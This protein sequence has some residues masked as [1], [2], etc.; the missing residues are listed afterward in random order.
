M[1]RT[2]RERF[3]GTLDYLSRY[4]SAELALSAKAVLIKRTADEIGADLAFPG[5]YDEEGDVDQFDA[6]AIKTI[7]N[8]TAAKVGQDLSLKGNGC[9]VFGTEGQH[10]ALRGLLMCQMAFLGVHYAKGG[11]N[12]TEPYDYNVHKEATVPFYLKKPEEELKKA[13]RC[14]LT[15]PGSRREDLILAAYTKPG[16]GN[17]T[18]WETTTR[19]TEPWPMSRWPV[20]FEALKMWLFKAGFVSLRWMAQKG[21][22]MMAQ[23]VNNLLGWGQIIQENDVTRIPP[24]YM[25]NFHKTGDPS[26]CHWGVSLGD[27]WAAAANTTADSVGATSKTFF[28]SGNEVYGEFSL[29]T[30]LEVLKRKYKST[31]NQNVA[32]VVT[33]RQIDP[34]TVAT[35][36]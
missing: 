17:E 14:Y 7:S 9:C 4:I 8:C 24:G 1:V 22:M 21:P 27:G 3:E 33:I 16:L 2:N 12:G 20:C 15:V 35:Y 11:L 28:R 19:E 29:A 18:I 6:L 34:T 32:N 23:T 30:C 13:I 31:P 5:S 25:F 10:W 26:V 36:F